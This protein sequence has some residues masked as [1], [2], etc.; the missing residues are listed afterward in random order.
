MVLA[1][2]RQGR[3]VIE[4]RGPQAQGITVPRVAVLEL[5]HSQFVPELPRPLHVLPG[6]QRHRRELGL[7]GGVDEQ[8]RV[9]AVVV[10]GVAVHA[11]QVDGRVHR[12]AAF[13]DAHVLVRLRAVADGPVDRREVLGVDVVV[14]R[15]HHLA[16]VVAE[17]QHR[18]HGLPR[19]QLVRLLHLHHHELAQV[20]QRLV[21]P[22]PD[23]ALQTAVVAQ[24]V[25]HQR[26]PAPVLDFAAFARR[27]LAQHAHVVGVL[28]V[29]DA[30]HLEHRAQAAGVHVP[31]GLSE[32][33]LGLEQVR[34]DVSL[35]DDLRVCR[36]L[37]VHGL[38]LDELHGP[39]EER[40]GDAELVHSVGD[41]LHGHVG[42]ARHRAD[43]AGRGQP[44]AQRVGLVPVDGQILLGADE[45]D[46]GLGGGLDLAAVV[47]D[48]ADAG[49]R[50]LGDP[51]AG[52]QVRPVVEPGRR[53]GHRELVE[54][55]V[56]QETVADVDLFLD[57][58]G[59]HH[60][61]R[62][63][64]GHRRGPLLEAFAGL[65][66]HA[67]GV[68]GL[69]G[70]QRPQH[71]RGLVTPPLGIHHV[72]EEK[73]LPL[74]VR[75]PQELPA[76]QRMQLRILVHRGSHAQQ[77]ALPVQQVEVFP[78]VLVHPQSLLS[79]SISRIAVHGSTKSCFP[80]L[81]PRTPVRQRETAPPKKPR[82]F[83]CL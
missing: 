72:L 26:L 9:L 21:H 7:L 48:V 41:L 27:H 13:D 12:L 81:I 15:D 11:Y 50:I 5:R 67:H 23:H 60:L 58:T 75:Q 32:G 47:A 57:R 10:A 29:G 66:A 17:A 69:V 36:H 83:C 68:D 65:A 52:G 77:Q 39:L 24:V 8:R 14:H 54:A 49:I 35:D 19:L 73:R 71:H 38:A 34:A 42:K 2:H 82:P 53:D 22:H 43:D 80:P 18:H 31:V 45:V 46:A 59:V 33:T 62:Q 78:E 70:S 6:G 61:R 56:V 4:L 28:P 64:T 40:T 51:V 30:G 3:L 20:H 76:H 55:A 37:Q 63:R 44:L 1:L 16:E 74:V 79:G 25:Q